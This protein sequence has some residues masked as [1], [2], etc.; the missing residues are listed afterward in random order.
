MKFKTPLKFC[1]G[2]LFDCEGA[3]FPISPRRAPLPAEPASIIPLLESC[4]ADNIN[5]LCLEIDESLI[6]LE[7]GVLRE[8]S[9]ALAALDLLL[10]E[11]WQRGIYLTI[12]PITRRIRIPDGRSEN[13]IRDDEPI[14]AERYYDQ[15]FRRVNPH[16]GRKFYKYENL[17]AIEPVL[18]LETFSVKRLWAYIHHM[19]AFVQHFF[20]NRLLE[21]YFT[22]RGPVPEDLRSCL[23]DFGFILPVN[24]FPHGDN[25]RFNAEIGGIRPAMF[26]AYV[27]E[28]SE[29]MFLPCASNECASQSRYFHNPRDN[30]GGEG[31][32]T[33]EAD[34]PI[35]LMLVFPCE[36][37]S[38][39]FR[40]SLREKTEVKRAGNTTVLTLQKPCYGALEINYDQADLPHFTAFILVDPIIPPPGEDTV[41]LE[42][43]TH[44][45]IDY[46]AAKTLAFKAGV[47]Q[48]PGA[49]L[50]PVSDHDVYLAPGAVLQGGLTCK[51]GQ[52]IRIFGSGIFDGT[53][54]ARQPG[55]NW[56][57]SADDAFIHFLGG[58]DICWDGPTVFNSPFWN[59]VPEGTENMRISHHKAL[60]WVANTDG[61]QP[62][63]CTNLIIEDCFFKCA[64]DAIA[65]K[66]RR[67]SAMHSKNIVVR[68][69]VTWNDAGS[70]LEI[71]HTSQADL[72]E[73]VR[74]E[75]IEIIRAVGG[76]IHIY[77]IDHCTVKNVHYDN[78]YIEGNYGEN[79][80]IS[81]TIGK[82]FYSTDEQRGQVRDVVIRNLHLCQQFCGVVLQGFDEQHR[83]ENV[84]LQNVYIHD[85][86]TVT[87]FRGGIPYFRCEFADQIKFI[88]S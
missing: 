65:I 3:V 87:E 69:I 59:L 31:F 15:L 29:S 20:L 4:V 70:A 26:Q 74:F 12:T 11:S 54:V 63:S 60:T 34:V 2:R 35:D 28:S 43:G 21:I 32:V 24:W 5:M 77:L 56:K 55:E 53:E 10:E 8:D 6:T 44:K 38:A 88:R 33:M 76:M 83:I 23:L 17:A 40:P 16:G 62:R 22:D 45:K 36:V 73:N 46:T 51:H 9:P 14:F 49:R 42:P 86:Q 72:L 1:N 48:L 41:W 82:N 47:H 66:T 64:D 30:G 52:N 79:P 71:G 81:F 85:G 27:K 78:I 37:K 50:C 67:A 13:A 80:E 84:S 61:I 19:R 7:N 39:V 68:N 75:N 58:K 18:A 25:L 57:G